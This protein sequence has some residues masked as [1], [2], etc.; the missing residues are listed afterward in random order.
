[1]YLIE[2]EYSELG[3]DKIK[4]I[5]DCYEIRKPEIQ[6][7]VTNECL[8]KMDCPVVTDFDWK[9]KWVVGSSTL[10]S[11]REP[12]MQMDLYT[13]QVDQDDNLH[14]GKINFEMNVHEL[15]QFIQE[16]EKALAKF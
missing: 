4:C 1:M 5:K 6:R 9:L 13:K 16:A 12:L 3:K 8:A 14:C 7:A 15:N 10:S 2:E 11:I